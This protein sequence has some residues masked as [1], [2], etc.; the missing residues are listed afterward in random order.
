MSTDKPPLWRVIFLAER[1]GRMTLTL[2]EVAEQIGLAPGT[3]RNRRTRGEF[4]WMRA[5]GRTLTADV[6]DVAA[7]L[8]ERRGAAAAEARGMPYSTAPAEHPVRRRRR[9]AR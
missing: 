7:Y 6:E 5:D 1:Y 4:A 8:T 3:I 9:P 2:D